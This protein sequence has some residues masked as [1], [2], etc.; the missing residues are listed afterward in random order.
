MDRIPFLRPALVSADKYVP[1]LR[2]IDATGLYSNYGPLNTRFEQRVL[3]EYFAGRGAVTTVGNATLGLMLA[4]K[5]LARPGARYALMPSFTFAATPLAAQWCG[6]MPWFVDIDPQTWCMDELALNAA[7]KK[8]GDDVAVVMPYPAFATCR[9][10][11]K[12][13]DLQRAGIPVVVDA[14]PSFGTTH[15]GMQFGADF[16]GAVVFS[17]HAT[18]A[19]GIGEGG[20]VYSANTSLVQQIRQLGN[21]GFNADRVAEGEGM[22]AKLPEYS[23]AIALATLDAFPAQVQARRG[24][25]ALYRDALTRS[26]LL[27]RGWQL[28]TMRGDI[29]VQ[30]LS[31]LVPQGLTAETVV[32]RMAADGI[33]VRRYFSPACHQHPQFSACPRD[34]MMVTENIARRVI[35]VPFWLGMREP[36]VD[37]VVTALRKITA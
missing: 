30:I 9:S 29:A 10:L 31:L 21:F 7:L 16:P 37:R 36:D 28:Q 35:N 26:G 15:D 27:Q 13:S 8:L 2:E 32:T 1:L 19:F 22:N 18:K 12:Y 3:A 5:A 23:A 20:L 11:E 34:A 4:V 6:L 24:L 25:H 14:A 17:L 33:E